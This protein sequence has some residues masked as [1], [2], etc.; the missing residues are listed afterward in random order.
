MGGATPSFWVRDLGAGGLYP[1]GVDQLFI[2]FSKATAEN[3]AK[4]HEE[5]SA[6][7]VIIVHEEFKLG[8]RNAPDQG[9]GK[10]EDAGR[11]DAWIEDRDFAKRVT[12]REFRQLQL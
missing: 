8:P 7:L 5:H 12:W 4:A 6:E 2:H 1:R 3:S 10:G 9:G 11:G